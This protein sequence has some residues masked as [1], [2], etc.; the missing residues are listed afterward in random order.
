LSFTREINAS[1]LMLAIHGTFFWHEIKLSDPLTKSK[2]NSVGLKSSRLK[3]SLGHTAT[4]PAHP[5]H[6]IE[7]IA[8]NL[9]VILIAPTG[10]IASHSVH[11]ELTLNA[12]TQRSGLKSKKLIVRLKAL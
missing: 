8:G 1:A 10:Q 3:A 9:S 2:K 12:R 5:T 4:H 6:V 7:L 11:I